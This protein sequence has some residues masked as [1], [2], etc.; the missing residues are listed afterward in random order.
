[1]FT[2]DYRV[3]VPTNDGYWVSEKFQT[4]AEVVKDYSQTLELRWIPP[5]MRTDPQ[6]RK[7]PYCI[8]DLVS[9]APIMYASE[10]DTPED[11]LTRLFLGDTS[12]HDVLATIDA[13]NAAVKALQMREWLGKLEEA[14]SLAEFMVGSPLNYIRMKDED[15]K[16]VKLDDSRRR[17]NGRSGDQAT[18][19]TPLRG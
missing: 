5:N 9:Q 13:H 11:I 16:I 8:F 2:D 19:Q 7:N 4:L 14:N 18:G 6:D 12:K 10:T 1:M 3:H 15:G 17:L